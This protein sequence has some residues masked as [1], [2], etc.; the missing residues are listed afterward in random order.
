MDIK[1][2]KQLFWWHFELIL[3]LGVAVDM[4]SLYRRGSFRIEHHLKFNSSTVDEWKWIYNFHIHGTIIRAETISLCNKFVSILASFVGTELAILFLKTPHG[5]YLGWL[6][7][8]RKIWSRS[9][10]S[11]ILTSWSRSKLLRTSVREWSKPFW[12]SKRDPG[13]RK[14]VVWPLSRSLWRRYPKR[15]YSSVLQEKS[16]MWS[17][18]IYQIDYERISGIRWNL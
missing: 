17:P 18:D 12:D 13:W 5:G 14:A 15:G 1:M 10:M 2:S 16:S 7:T 3:E 4:K 9:N 8:E 11:F 6:E